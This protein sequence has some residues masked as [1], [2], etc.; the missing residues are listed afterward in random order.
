MPID[1]GPTF[2][3]VHHWKTSANGPFMV[4]KV[5]V[6]DNRILIYMKLKLFNVFSKLLP[7]LAYYC[8]N[9]TLFLKTSGKLLI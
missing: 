1:A 3:L 6:G 2:P 9:N 7:L 4:S 5:C 8:R